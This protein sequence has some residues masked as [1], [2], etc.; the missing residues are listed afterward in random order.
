MKVIALSGWRGSG[1]DT[2][3]NFLSSYGYQRVSFAGSIKDLV[4]RKYKIPRYYC[5]DPDYKESPLFQYEV[6]PQ[7]GFTNMISTFMDKE[8]CVREG[9]KYWTP[10]ALC[11]LEGSV[12]RS[13]SSSFW[14]EK[15]MDIID[16]QELSIITDFRYQSEA[17]QLRE[18]YGNNLLF[19]RINRFET[20][21]S[22]DPSERDLDDFIFDVVIENKGSLEELQEKVKVLV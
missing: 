10:R 3:G 8:F 12:A 17:K 19:A 9:R 5:D 2:V 14:V 13:V 6:I 20:C 1:K 21:K 22:T 7:D 16:F 18:R 4:S 15:T 11:I